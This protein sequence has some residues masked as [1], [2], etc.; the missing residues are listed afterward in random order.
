MTNKEFSTIVLLPVILA[1]GIFAC[2]KPASAEPASAMMTANQA[3]P[4]AEPNAI[5]DA[6]FPSAGLSLVAMTGLTQ[7]TNNEGEI[8]LGRV[9]VLKTPALM[10][11]FRLNNATNKALTLDRLQTSCHC[12]SAVWEMEDGKPRL[13]TSKSSLTLL[14]GKSIAVEVRLNLMQMAPGEVVKSVSVFLKGQ[15]QPAALVTFIADVQPVVSFWPH[16]IDFGQVSAASPRTVTLTADFDPVLASKGSL[17]TLVS[18]NPSIQIT[19]A[20]VPSVQKSFI[21][22]TYTLTLL[23]TVDGLVSGSLSFAP[24]SSTK[25]DGTSSDRNF[26]ALSAISLSVQGQVIG[27][28]A[29]EPSALSLGPVPGKHATAGHVALTGQTEQSLAGAVVES[30]S[31]YVAVH[32]DAARAETSDNTG[33]GIKVSNG[34]GGAQAAAN[35]QTMSIIVKPN[36]PLGKLQTQVRVTLANGQILLVSVTAYVIAASAL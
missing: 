22:R 20:S 27:S 30:D 9:S 7:I 15:T 33:S 29:A 5:L 12:T 36:A 8:D 24:A 25:N 28:V 16:Q 4:V 13:N 35:S 2:L 1:A 3:A 34:F 32:L 26:A 31:P 11:M 10:Q 23:P 18:S 21:R 19:A 17:P 6:R 14:P